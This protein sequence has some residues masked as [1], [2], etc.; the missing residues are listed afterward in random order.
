MILCDIL[1]IIVLL[2]C[3]YI[4]DTEDFKSLCHQEVV[5]KDVLSALN[6]MSGDPLENID[7][8]IL[9]CAAYKQ[10]I[11]LVHNYLGI[12]N[13]KVIPSCAIWSIR[14]KFPS[15]TNVYV[16]Y[17]ESKYEEMSKK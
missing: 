2:G 12:G 14:D 13:R 15:N 11:W 9:R 3:K 16:P 8:N 5:L 17:M 4:S 7:N 10:Y 6:D 1:I